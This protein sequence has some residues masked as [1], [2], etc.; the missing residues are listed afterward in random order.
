MNT[1]TG[2]IYQDDEIKKALERGEPVADLTEDEGTKL[3]ALQDEIRERLAK[4][5]ELGSPTARIWRI[6]P[7]TGELEWKLAHWKAMD[8]WH[9]VP[10]QADVD[11]LNNLEWRALRVPQPN[12][13]GNEL[14]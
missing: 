12:W 5:Q 14:R 9:M 6:S 4:L 10:T 8:A 13:L 7:M 3:A 1:E 2:T 11:Y